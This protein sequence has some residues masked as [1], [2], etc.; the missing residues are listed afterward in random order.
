MTRIVSGDAQPF[1]GADKALRPQTLAEF[2]GQEQVKANLRVF[3]EGARS[4]VRSSR[5]GACRHTSA[6]L[7]SL[8]LTRA[9]RSSASVSALASRAPTGRR[10]KVSSKKFVRHS[11][12]SFSRK[13]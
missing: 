2:V 12:S 8:R 6:C 7:V 10:R 5:E 3:I 1:E 13:S 4:R 11:S 9:C